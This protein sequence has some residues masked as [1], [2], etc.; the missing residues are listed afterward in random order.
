MPNSRRKYMKGGE[1]E[2]K[3]PS[4]SGWGWFGL[5]KKPDTGNNDNNKSVISNLTATV[6]SKTNEMLG[7]RQAGESTTSHLNGEIEKLKKAKVDLE[8]KLKEDL[9]KNDS[10]HETKKSEDKK[11][12]EETY[13]NE[14]TNLDEKI[15]DIN[16]QIQEVIKESEENL[17]YPRSTSPPLSGGRG[18][19]RIRTHRSRA[20]R[21]GA[22]R[23]KAHRSRAHR[24]KAYKEK[25]YTRKHRYSRKKKYY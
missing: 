16:K 21:S 11:K 2:T 18:T 5:N 4:P 25:K 20:H 23:S 15:N 12:I 22:H 7:R 9:Q 6:S 8:N 17:K 14:K 24:S 10:M 13:N 19:R 1:G 3:N